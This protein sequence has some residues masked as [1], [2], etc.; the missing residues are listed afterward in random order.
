MSDPPT[1]P[2][3]AEEAAILDRLLDGKL[4]AIRSQENDRIITTRAAADLRVQVLEHHLE[5]VI[6]L[7][8]EHFTEPS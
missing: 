4:A 2:T 5:A 3:Y 1:A 7:R 8:A 6:A